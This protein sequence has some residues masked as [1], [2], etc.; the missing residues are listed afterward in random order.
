MVL[1]AAPPE[2]P[3][4]DP[5]TPTPTPAHPPVVPPAEPPTVPPAE[6]TPPAPPPAEPPADPP[7]RPA[8]PSV[9]PQSGD[10]DPSKPMIALTFDDG[11]SKY[12]SHVLDILEK[13]GA[14]ATFCVVGNIVNAR[15]ETVKRTS[16]LGCEVIGHSWSHRDLSKLSSEEIK[17]ELNDT[18]AAIEA[19]T[20]V[21]PRLYRPP[22]GAVNNTL[23][24]VSAELGYAIIYWSVDPLDW[25]SRNA[26]KIHTAIMSEAG[27][28]AI[29]LSHDLYGSTADAMERVIP[30]LI[31]KG[32]QLVTVSEL[33]YYSD[34][35][36]EAGV[37]YYSGK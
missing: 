12:T 32:Y 14:R 19:I 10:I 3:P 2:P 30:E 20:G 28:Y 33:M 7:V 31:S 4:A 24:S 13:Y 37:V 29:V 6:L 25:S 17:K 1:G 26:D 18:S 11:P 21:W 22:Y 36:L 8:I 5:P 15:Q 9:P 27:N 16:D 34:K 23:K 35:T